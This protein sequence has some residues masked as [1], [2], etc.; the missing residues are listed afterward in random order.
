MITLL[1]EAHSTS[2]DNEA[3]LASGFND[4]DLSPLGLKQA[5]ALGER[6][7]TTPIAAIYSSDLQRAYKTAI[8]AFSNR[9]IP[10][11][12]DTRLRECDYGDY[13]QKDADIV[14][15]M[16]PQCIATPFPNGESYEQVCMRMQD[17]LDEVSAH[18]QSGETIIIIGHRGTQY[19]IECYIEGK[20]VEQAV[21]A[22]WQWQPGWRY[23]LKPRS[24]L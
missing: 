22:P 6:H 5:K 24:A 9:H 15:A 14:K 7:T 20:T 11:F 1:F 23:E 19:G 13:T 12:T 10:L 17:F 2:Y 18:H 16:K 3:K 21:T 4:V 8:I